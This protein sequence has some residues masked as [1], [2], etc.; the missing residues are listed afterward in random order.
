MGGNTEGGEVMEQ[1]SDAWKLDQD[2]I[3]V[4]REVVDCDASRREFCQ[5]AVNRLVAA[6]HHEDQ[7]VRFCASLVAEQVMEML[8]RVYG[9]HKPRQ[10]E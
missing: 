7:S 8:D 1:R 3:G 10:G 2:E 6:V 4:Q 5:R 9:V